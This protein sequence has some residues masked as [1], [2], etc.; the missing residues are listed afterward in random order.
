MKVGIVTFHH[1]VNY[2]AVLQTYALQQYLSNLGIDSDV[3]DYRCPYIEYFYKPIKAN[4]IKNGKMFIR[5]ILYYSCNKKKRTKFNTFLKHY[6]KLSKVVKTQQE[7]EQINSEYDF[8]IAGSDQVWNLKWSG[9]D[10]TYFL[11]FADTN[12]KYSYAASFGFDRIPNEQKQVY[13]QLLSEFQAISVRENTG[14]EIIRELLK[15]ESEVSV[16]PTCLIT[17][18]EWEKICVYP[19]EQGYILI[20]ML[21]HSE[22]LISFAEKV[23]RE[24]RAKIIYI[25][26]ALRKEYNF[27]YRGALSPT[28]F[29]GLFANAGYVITNSF[30]GLMFSVIFEKEFCIQYQKKPEA[31]NS[32]LIDFI[33]DYHLENRLLENIKMEEKPDYILVNQI[34][35]KKVEQS[36]RF[37]LS[38]PI[39]SKTDVIQLPHKKEEC[40]GCRACEQICPMAAISMQMDEEG[41][42]YP[43]INHDICVK[44]RKCIGVCTLYNKD[45]PKES[46]ENFHAKVV[47][48]YQKNEK[49]RMKSRSG[50]VFVAVSEVVLKEQGVVYGAGFNDDL[51]VQHMRATTPDERNTFC[52]SKYVQS[53]TKSTFRTVFEDLQNNKRVLFSGTACQ[54]AGLYSYLEKKG[55]AGKF[56]NLITVDIVCHGVVSPEIWKENLNEISEKLGTKPRIADFRDKSF[57]WG[58]H[59][60]SYACGNKKI[61]SERYTA[62]FYENICLRPCC[63]NCHY[64]SVVRVSD[65]T[66]AD[67]WGIHRAVPDWDFEKGVSLVLLNTEKGCQYFEKAQGDLTTKEVS[68]EQFMQ[69][70][71]QYP[72]NRPTNRDEIMELYKK[73]GYVALADWC[74]KKRKISIRKNRIKSKIVKIMRT[75]HLK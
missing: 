1:A 53:D 24:R 20:Y 5:E 56:D 14:K 58:S 19:K 13:Q 30:H 32:R 33:H 59:I 52:G 15:R 35:K 6:I 22:E 23:S 40:C 72:S 62:I 28:E 64:A 65:I 2:G 63:Y 26:D 11:D 25:S 18:A 37:L 21:D 47:V 42:I 54:I 55:I 73:R 71:L 3:I 43:V 45:N 48:A 51:I 16:D 10:K 60:E 49:K 29:I 57:G 17:K 75:F 12:K 4:P 7:L 50:G 39:A 8:F 41:F 34:M 38:L 46:S 44:C 61:T 9:L 69:P 27:E 68:I 31:P 74:E 70:N 36:K 67:A 66:L